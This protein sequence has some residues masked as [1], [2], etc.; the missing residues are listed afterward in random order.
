M[1]K[2]Q[3]QKLNVQQKRIPWPLDSV[4]SRYIAFV[5]VIEGTFSSNS[6][7]VVKKNT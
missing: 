1:Y 7:F 2:Q 3:I 6:K 5:E 4:V